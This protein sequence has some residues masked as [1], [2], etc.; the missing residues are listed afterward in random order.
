MYSTIFC[1]KINDLGIKYK[2][3]LKKKK[4]KTKE[5]TWSEVCQSVSCDHFGI[6]MTKGRPITF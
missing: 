4:G 5:E 1:E 2:E 6:S 3:C